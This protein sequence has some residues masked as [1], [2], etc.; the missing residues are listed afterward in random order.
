MNQEKY[1]TKEQ[2]ELMKKQYENTDTETMKKVEQ[3]FNTVL[4]EL[5]SHMEEGTPA[6]DIKVQA[7]QRWHRSVIYEQ[8]HL[9]L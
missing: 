8:C 4:D 6:T 2:L 7:K 3:D 5:R 1:F 9:Y